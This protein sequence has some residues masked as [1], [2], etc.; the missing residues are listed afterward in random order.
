[1]GGDMRKTRGMLPL[2]T[3]VLLL[4]LA[5]CGGD[6]DSSGT[7]AGAHVATTARSAPSAESSAAADGTTE[8]TA[9][10]TT[11]RVAPAGMID[12]CSLVTSEEAAAALGGP[13]DPPKPGFAGSFSE[14]LWRIEGG[15]EMDSAVVVHAL[16]GVSR[17]QF[18]QHV[19]ENA[20]PE[21]G[22][23]EPVSGVGDIAY[24]QIALFALA[25]DAMVVVTVLSNDPDGGES[26]QVA[27]A[28][29]AIGRL[30]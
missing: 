18:E 26:Q 2:S 17:D 27:L 23:V 20:P 4:A 8:T 19:E 1:M 29:A 3:C 5:G 30:P 7:T 15:T 9:P 21:L 10:V 12:A 13:V 16:G 24:Q 14:C 6:D 11:A 28:Q 25:G 22:P